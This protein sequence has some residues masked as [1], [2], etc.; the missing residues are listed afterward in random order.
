MALEIA[1]K[2]E[3]DPIKK[4]IYAQKLVD[5]EIGINTGLLF[6]GGEA[7]NAA[8][9][10]EKYNPTAANKADAFIKARYGK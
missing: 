7:P 5:T 3:T 8:D 6:T 9:L 2:K 10:K 4:G 1:Y